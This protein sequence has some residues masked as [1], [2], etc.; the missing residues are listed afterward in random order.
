MRKL[1]MV[2]LGVVALGLS[3]HTTRG[4][5]EKG[6]VRFAIIGLSHDH[7]AGFIPRA[8]DRQ[9]AQLVGIVEPKEELRARYA[10]RF[11]LDTNLFYSS[12][13]ELL[14]RTKVQAVATFTSTFE[15][16]RVVET[17]AARGI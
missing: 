1:L 6:P 3:I 7:A 2:W 10:R 11:Q 17:C 9:E 15:H 12:I 13:E 5:A 16:R 4:E 14:A 8:R